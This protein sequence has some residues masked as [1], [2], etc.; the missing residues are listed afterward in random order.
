[1]ASFSE[2]MAFGKGITE[3]LGGF[4]QGDRSATL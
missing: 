2:A 3:T 1:M 4:A